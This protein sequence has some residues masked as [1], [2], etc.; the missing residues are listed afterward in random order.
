MNEQELLS[1][2]N[3]G[4]EEKALDDLLQKH[5]LTI[6]ILNEIENNYISGEGSSKMTRIKVEYINAIDEFKNDL[7]KFHGI[8]IS[9]P[10][11]VNYCIKQAIIK[12]NLKKSK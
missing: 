1:N 4:T 6:S 8:K 9:I 11:F 7:F 3:F 2:F 12:Y 5:N 10:S